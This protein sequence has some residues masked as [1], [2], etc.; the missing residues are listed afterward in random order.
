MATFN[1]DEDALIEQAVA[2]VVERIPEA[3]EFHRQMVVSEAPK[4]S[5]N[6]AATVAT[7]ILPDAHGWKVVVR[8]YYSPFDE[9]GTKH[10]RANPFL[11]RATF[12]ALPRILQ[13]LEGTT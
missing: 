4:K 8:A 5:G 12:K 7:V 13:I 3:A 2:Q 6:L 1:I 10:Q 11:L 9:F